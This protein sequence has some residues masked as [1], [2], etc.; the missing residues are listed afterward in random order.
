MKVGPWVGVPE[1]AEPDR[2]RPATDSGQAVPS[3]SNE[4]GPGGQSILP[5]SSQV[6][7]IQSSVRIGPA[8]GIEASLGLGD[9]S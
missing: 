4:E 1:A 8:S 6:A 5:A 7:G 9:E 3:Q 2:G